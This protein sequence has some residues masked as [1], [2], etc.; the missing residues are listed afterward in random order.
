M[1]VC[2]FSN[3]YFKKWVWSGCD[4]KVTPLLKSLRTP[5]TLT[6]PL[7]DCSNYS[8]FYHTHYLT[9]DQSSSDIS[10]VS[11]SQTHYHAAPLE[12][13][14]SLLLQRFT[15]E[16]SRELRRT[17]CLEEAE[18]QAEASVDVPYPPLQI[19]NSV[20]YNLFSLYLYPLSAPFLYPLSSPTP[21][22]S[23]ILCPPKIKTSSFPTFCFT[24][25]T[26]FCILFHTMTYFLNKAFYKLVK[27]KF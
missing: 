1:L 12:T 4:H 15:A 10:L 9:P 18:Q 2:C 19:V 5:L 27:N 20:T 25:G 26:L 13:N 23:S 17:Q 8:P 6:N 3:D 14:T 7:P 21:P 11:S 22:S 16:S 24:N